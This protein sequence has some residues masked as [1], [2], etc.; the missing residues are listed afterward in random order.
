MAGLREI[1][2]LEKAK[3]VCIRS[4]LESG[5]DDDD[6]LDFVVYQTFSTIF[7]FCLL[8]L[9]GGDFRVVVFVALPPSLSS[10]FS[11]HLNDILI[12]KVCFIVGFLF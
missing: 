10:S 7:I 8:F 2:R 11:F 9:S 5:G 1:T 6:D 4:E 12:D 3:T